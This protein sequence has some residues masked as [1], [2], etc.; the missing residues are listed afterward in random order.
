MTQ[1]TRSGSESHIG[2]RSFNPVE[3]RHRC[4]GFRLPRQ[5]DRMRAAS[6]E[7]F[8]APENPFDPFTHFFVPDKLAAIGL[9]YAALH[10]RHEFRVISKRVIDGISHQL[11]DVLAVGGGDTSKLRFDLGRE[12][13]FHIATIALGAP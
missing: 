11:L 12:V 5:T 6:S 7:S 2:Q 8:S 10:V 9:L 3:N 1:V 13:D 4:C